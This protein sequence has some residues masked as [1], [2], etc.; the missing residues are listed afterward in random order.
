MEIFKL[1]DTKI[2]SE[3]ENVY[4]RLNTLS[5]YLGD[6]GKNE[7]GDTS[8]VMAEILTTIQYINNEINYLETE[9]RRL[10]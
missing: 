6:T 2:L 4:R 8:T 3:L 9:I 10:K 7:K 5:I 1:K